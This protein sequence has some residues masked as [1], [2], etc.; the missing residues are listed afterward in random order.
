MRERGGMIMNFV[1]GANLTCNYIRSPGN[2]FGWEGAS[3][4]LRREIEID[5]GIQR[6]SREER[7]YVNGILGP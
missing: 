7:S 3:L 4:Q 6:G 5:G 1:Q 2:F